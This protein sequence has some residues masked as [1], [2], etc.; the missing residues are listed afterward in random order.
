MW[1]KCLS[2][3]MDP[4][5][6]WPTMPPLSSPGGLMSPHKRFSCPTVKM[7]T[8]RKCQIPGGCTELCD[9]VWEVERG[10]CHQRGITYQICCFYTRNIPGKVPH[11]TRKYS[12]P[13][14]IRGDM[15][16]QNAVWWFSPLQIKRLTSTSMF[17]SPPSTLCL[18]LLQCCSCDAFLMKLKHVYLPWKFLFFR[19]QKGWRSNI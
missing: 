3:F 6:V 11:D 13:P 4:L 18:Y 2:S 1:N 12:Q 19:L 10:A 14:L 5:S 7:A 17:L 15:F 16:T 8:R 9:A